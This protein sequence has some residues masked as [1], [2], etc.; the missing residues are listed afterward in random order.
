VREELDLWAY[1]NGM[2]PDFSRPD[3]PTN[4]ALIEPFNSK[5]RAECLNANWF[6]SLDEARAKSEA[7]QRD[8]N[9]AQ[10]HSAIGN[11]TAIELHRMAASPAAGGPPSRSKIYLYSIPELFVKKPF[12]FL[13]LHP[14]RLVYRNFLTTYVNALGNINWFR[15]INEFECF[16]YIRQCVTE[17]PA[18]QFT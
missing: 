10:P 11:K 2:T 17:T 5:F 12:S 1:M 7:W 9:V 13:K 8:Y 3:K 16:V 6:L 4:N 15:S 18:Q 14:Q